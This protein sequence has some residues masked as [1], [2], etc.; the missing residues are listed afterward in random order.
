MMMR[1]KGCG[2]M[3]LNVDL[4]GLKMSTPVTTAS[5]TFGYGT[6]YVDLL[7]YS[8]LG[9]VTVKG[10]R[11]DPWPGNAMP[12]HCEIPGGMV[13]AIGLQGPGVQPFIDHYIGH[14]C[15]TVKK[16]LE[17]RGCDA[18][19]PPMIVNIWGGSIEEYAEVAKTL[20]DCSFANGDNPVIGAIECNVS[21]PNVKEGGHTFG[22]DPAVLSRLV[23]AVRAATKLPLIVKLAPNVPDL[24]PY[25][26]ACEDNGADA[27]ALI[28]TI[29]AMVIDINTRKPV[30]ANR[31]GGLSG[32]CVHPVAVKCVYD[33]HRFSKLPILAMGGVYSWQDAVELM[34][35]GATAVAVG[36]ATFTSPAV[37]A[38]VADGIAAYCEKNGFASVREL[39]GALAE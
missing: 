24:K 34:L 33:A 39:S 21:C 31:T 7:D 16:S 18:P 6:E 29:P 25:T 17:R 22:Q 14:Y 9:A 32:R 4:G 35:A 26:A 19:V 37:A 10:V 27:L 2:I 3:D 20:S 28:N 11:K 30:L 1:K 13:N 36:T 8:K 12:R 15:D 5:G 23:K 38:D